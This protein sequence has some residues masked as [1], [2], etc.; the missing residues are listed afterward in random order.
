MERNAEELPMGYSLE[1]PQPRQPGP[2]LYQIYWH[3]VLAFQPIIYF[4]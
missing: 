3:S 4:I 2:E 1:C